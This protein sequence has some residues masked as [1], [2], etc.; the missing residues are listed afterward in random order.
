MRSD[1]APAGVSASPSGEPW[2]VQAPRVPYFLPHS[3]QAVPD[4]V[5]VCTPE[6]QEL[7][8]T[9]RSGGR[10]SVTR[11]AC[12]S[13]PNGAML[14]YTITGGEERPSHSTTQ[15]LTAAWH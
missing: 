12:Q 9:A 3:Q 10:Q 13:S 5:P 1:R 7:R 11:L 15:P 8:I 14:S 6:V 4:Q 2:W